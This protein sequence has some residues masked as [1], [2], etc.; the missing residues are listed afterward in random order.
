M[1]YIYQFCI[2]IALS[3]AGEAAAYVIKLPIPAGIYGLL[4]ML[5]L[6]CLKIIPIGAVRTVGMFLI[7]IM[8]LMFIPSAVGLLESWGLFQKRLAAYLLITVLSTVVVM[9]LSG[10]VT[11]Y[12][13][14]RGGKDGRA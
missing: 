12:F 8:P 3:L 11:Q 9:V 14:R 7:E 10:R 4:L 1:K 5:L 2:I 13:L 6:L